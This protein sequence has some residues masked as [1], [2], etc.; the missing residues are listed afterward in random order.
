MWKWK[1]L[2]MHG[3]TITSVMDVPGGYIVRTEH[4]ARLGRGPDYQQHPVPTSTAL[5]F[6]PYGEPV[7]EKLEV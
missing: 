6:V 1:S 4:E 2:P 3:G 7:A 5:V